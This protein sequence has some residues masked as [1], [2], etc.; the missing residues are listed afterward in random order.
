MSALSLFEAAIVSTSTMYGFRFC[1]AYCIFNYFPVGS[2]VV[3]GILKFIFEFLI[4]VVLGLFPFQ[5]GL[6]PFFTMVL[7]V[8]NVVLVLWARL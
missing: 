3:F 8:R 2:A 7:Y 6:P 4:T 1:V 5:F